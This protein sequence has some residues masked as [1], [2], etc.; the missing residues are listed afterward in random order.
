MPFDTTPVLV[1]GHWRA[2]AATLPLF[3]PSTGAE[4]ARIARGGAAEVDAAV[5][6]A[7]AALDGE[8]GA[9]TAAERG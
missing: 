9:L 1:A 2:T 3:N 5:Q 4:L 7:Q 8:W 6:A